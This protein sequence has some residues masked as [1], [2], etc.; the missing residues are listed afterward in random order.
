MTLDTLIGIFELVAI[1][2]TLGVGG[3]SITFALVFV[4]LRQYYFAQRKGYNPIAAGSILVGA[5]VVL[6][7]I[8]L[9]ILDQYEGGD[10]S[11]AEKNWFLFLSFAIIFVGPPLVATAF[12]M[13]LPRNARR[14]GARSTSF[15]LSNTARRL[16]QGLQWGYLLL[17]LTSF[18]GGLIDALLF[19]AGIRTTRN[20]NLTPIFGF[21]MSFGILMALAYSLFSHYRSR[22][23]APAL[24]A[25]V[26]ADPRPPVLYLRA[27]YQESDAFQIVSIGEAD[28]YT[29]RPIISSKAKAISVTFE[30]YLSSAI[31]QRIGPFIALG[32]PEDFMPPEGA[33]R[34]YAEDRNWQ[35]Q[36]LKLAETAKAIVMEVSRSDNLRWEIAA[37]LSHGWQRKLFVITPPVWKSSR[38]YRWF[39]VAL[40]AAKGVAAPRWSEFASELN[41]AGFQVDPA[42]PGPGSTVSFDLVGASEVIAR[43]ASEPEDFVSAIQRRLASLSLTNSNMQS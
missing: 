19:K 5:V 21:S 37:L 26:T 1:L 7:T 14:A 29:A 22:A 16:E 6:F 27:F 32:N 18:T 15:L 10:Q 40:R 41:N 12:V 33:A 23:A 20:P 34:E 30:Q 25:V 38:M 3:F 17:V 2:A 36:F 9:V 24:K 42:D 13:A 28:R 31:S 11:E 43:R 39:L 35:Q 4:Y 8:T